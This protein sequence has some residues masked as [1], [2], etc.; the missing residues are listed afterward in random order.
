MYN[1]PIIKMPNMNTVGFDEQIQFVFVLLCR[2]ALDGLEQNLHR[3]NDDLAQKINSLNLDNKCMDVR[4][5]LQIRPQTALERN[6]TL[7]GIQRERS[8]ILA[9]FPKKLK[10]KEKSAFQYQTML[11]MFYSISIAFKNCHVI[12]QL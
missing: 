4:K 7:T 9:Q 11:S 10:S 8:H 1:V 6:L 2:H 3:I 5:K 12:M